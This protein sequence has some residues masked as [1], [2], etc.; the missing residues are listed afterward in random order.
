MLLGTA[1][2]LQAG[3]AFT[4]LPFA[5]ALAAAMLIHLGTNLQNDVSDF[6]RGADGA[7]RIGPPRACTQGWLGAG[8]VQTA[9]IA[10]F[11]LS[12]VPG[13]VL[14]HEFGW[15][16]AILGLASIAAGAAYTAGPWPTGYHGLGELFVLVFFGL[17]AVAGSHYLQ[18]FEI[19]GSALLGGLIVGM[20]STAILVINN[21]RDIESDTRAGKRTLAVRFGRRFA[22]NE[23][24]VLVLMPF[25][26]APLLGS[27]TPA[28]PLF[29]LPA[30][31]MLP[32]ALSL[33]RDVRSHP[34]GTGL[35]TVLAR[36][37]RL[38]LFTGLLLCAGTLVPPDLP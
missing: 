8:Q 1:L 23:Y 29:A 36:T 3:H 19:S 14:V 11:A 15:P 17:A 27:L 5:C 30:L 33:A 31:L 24:A 26:L 21:L 34:K 13:I 20:L 32:M 35:N 38:L 10:C 4:A 6:R 25:V 7:G 37:N 22:V 2:A 28:G 9:A 16:F 12:L 18:S